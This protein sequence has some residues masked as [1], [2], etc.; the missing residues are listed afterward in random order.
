M[1]ANTIDETVVERLRELPVDK[2][3]EVLE[4]A[5]ILTPRK[6]SPWKS[7]R[8]HWKGVGSSITA[9]QIDETRKGMWATFPRDEFFK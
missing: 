1:A 3:M 4:F 8:G 5:N 2:Q 6:P 7:V 9:E